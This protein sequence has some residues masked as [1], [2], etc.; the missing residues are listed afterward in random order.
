MKYGLAYP[1][2]AQQRVDPDHVQLW[3]RDARQNGSVGVL[4]RV[5]GENE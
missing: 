5:E 4:M 2:G 3:M 1:D